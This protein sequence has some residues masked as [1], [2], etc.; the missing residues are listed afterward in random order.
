MDAGQLIL[1]APWFEAY[2]REFLRTMAFADHETFDYP[3]ACGHLACAEILHLECLL[4]IPSH[5]L[6]S[7]CHVKTWQCDVKAC[8]LAP[9]PSL[10]PERLIHSI[11]SIGVQVSFSHFPFSSAAQFA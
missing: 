2:K 1:Q 9:Q 6:E 4:H 8:C 11:L 5:P 7:G 3:V 10:L